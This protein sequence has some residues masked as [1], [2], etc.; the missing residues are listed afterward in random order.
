MSV[1]EA[2]QI[3]TALLRHA[4]GIGEEARKRLV[5]TSPDY[6]GASR[7]LRELSA[8]FDREIPRIYGQVFTSPGGSMAKEYE[9]TP[10]SVEPF[11]S[12]AEALDKIRSPVIVLGAPP[13]P[14]DF[15]KRVELI[16]D[17]L[18]VWRA[19]F[20]QSEVTAEV[21]ML[22]MRALGL[23]RHRLRSLTS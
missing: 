9:Y 3:I 2:H 19:R 13:P 1:N 7:K 4:D 6:A 8:L 17:H 20:D 21:V 22:A 14:D 18:R 11:P 5:E 16:A 23:M 15:G 12:I 10:A